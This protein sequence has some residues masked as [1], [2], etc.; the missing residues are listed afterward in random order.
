MKNKYIILLVVVLMIV[1]LPFLP[2]IYKRFTRP[3]YK[4]VVDAKEWY[5]KVDCEDLA[6][7]QDYCER[8][9][10]STD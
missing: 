6:Q 5:G 4:S 2:L 7:V 10:Y 9:G 3:L 8:R 1:S